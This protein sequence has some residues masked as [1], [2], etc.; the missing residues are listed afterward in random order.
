MDS[1][2]SQA[3]KG[4]EKLV[5]TLKEVC[6]MLDM[7]FEVTEQDEDQVSF[8]IDRIPFSLSWGECPAAG[9][10]GMM[11]RVVYQLCVWY[12]TMGTR[13]DPPETI[14]TTLVDSAYV[15][16]CVHKALET[17]FMAR[18]DGVLENQGYAEMLAEEKN[19]EPI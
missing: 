11:W 14:D 12:T 6:P 9:I 10:G 18:V 19:L 5:Q 3:E 4:M 13:H 7:T 15:G 16:V 2:K 17:V 1:I 8:N